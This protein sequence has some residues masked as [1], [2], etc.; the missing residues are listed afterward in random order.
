MFCQP[1]PNGSEVKTRRAP[2]CEP[3]VRYARHRT[4]RCRTGQ[5]RPSSSELA[6]LDGVEDHMV[7]SL[8]IANRWMALTR[9]KNRSV[10]RVSAQDIKIYGEDI[11]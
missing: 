5:T 4:L 11:Q 3:A 9:I 1:S 10:H 8:A 6:T 7:F 2:A